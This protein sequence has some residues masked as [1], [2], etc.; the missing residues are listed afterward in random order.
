[1]PLMPDLVQAE[2]DRLRKLKAQKLPQLTASD[3]SKVQR[4]ID[5]RSRALGA[6]AFRGV[7]ISDA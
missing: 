4:P 2:I 5:S 6:A 1:M 7:A 3:Y